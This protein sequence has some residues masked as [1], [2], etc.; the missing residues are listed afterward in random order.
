MWTVLVLQVLAAANATLAGVSVKLLVDGA[1]TSSMAQAFSGA[2]GLAL[3]IGVGL[4]LSA[5]PVRL[6]MV[7]REKTVHLMEADLLRVAARSPGLELQ[8]N[9]THLAQ[10]ELWQ[11]ESWQFSQAVVSLVS[12]VTFTCRLTFT[13]ILLASISPV[14]LLLPLFGVP[15]LLLSGKTSGLFLR[16]IELSAEPSRRAE[17]L[18]GLA[19]HANAA[20]EL[21]AFCLEAEI[22]HRFHLAHAEIRAIHRTLQIHARLLAIAPRLV[23]VAGYAL[24]IAYVTALAAAGGA[25]PGD[26]LLTAVLAGQVLSWLTQSSELVQF[27]L[28]TLAAVS[29]FLYLLDAIRPIPLPS[30]RLFDPP[31]RLNNGIRLRHVSFGYDPGR[32][33]LHDVDLHLPA[34]STVALVGDNGAGKT[35]LVKL[36]AGYYQPSAGDITIDGMPL[37]SIDLERWRGRISAVFQDYVRL[38]LLARE[39]VGVGDLPELANAGAVRGALRRADAEQLVDGWPAGLET[40][41]GPTFPDGVDVSGGEWQKLALARG[42]MRHHPLLLILDEPAAALDPESEQE[43]F[44]RYALAAKRFASNS[45]GI[46]VLVSHRFSTVRM[47]DLICVLVDGRVAEFGTHAELMQAGGEYAALFTLQARAYT[48]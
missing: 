47:A 33:V 42:L 3:F 21:R 40:Q 16:G 18:F 19:T 28:R 37:R 15:S 13:A 34:G 26:V 30:G 17:A 12:L 4:L 32:T 2:V 24:S 41:L 5:G 46:T 38:E 35:T 48:A 10:L 6:M 31:A 20:K 1:R 43:L 45:G 25:S 23:F 36:L 27:T 39:S 8:E 11:A 29:R 44:E 14:L 22:L 7:L 9:H